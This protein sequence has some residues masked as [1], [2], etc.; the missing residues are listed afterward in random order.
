[1]GGRSAPS[2]PLAYT[3]A[4]YDAQKQY[5]KQDC[6]I[7]LLMDTS[8]KM[9]LQKHILYCFKESKELAKQSRKHIWPRSRQVT[10]SSSL[11]T[12]EETQTH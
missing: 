9:R 8:P 6:S 5:Q 10:W 11:C 3:L 7:S 2:F 4:A 1:M 12:S